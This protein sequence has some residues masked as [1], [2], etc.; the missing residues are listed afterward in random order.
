MI[1]RDFHSDTKSI[2]NLVHKEIQS[3][4][5]LDYSYLSTEYEYS[6]SVYNDIN[7]S[8]RSLKIKLLNSELSREAYE[9]EKKLVEKRI[10]RTSDKNKFTFKTYTS[11][12]H[13]YN[14]INYEMTYGF[15]I[16]KIINS[17]IHKTEFIDTR[18]YEHLSL[19]RQENLD[20]NI[21]NI[22][23]NINYYNNMY[24]YINTPSLNVSID[25]T[26][27]FGKDLYDMYMHVSSSGYKIGNAI[28]APNLDRKS[29]IVT[30]PNNQI[31]EGINVIIDEKDKRFLYSE[32][33]NFDYKYYEIP[34][35]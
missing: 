5:T 21:R 34:I 20:S 25:P 15:I 11:R 10:K 35:I 8:L 18:R 27:I 16:N 9:K 31:S 7:K 13:E 24:V 23:T 4:E 29:I 19:T 12:F 32:T 22:L 3:C 30:I 33:T 1:N 26:L 6:D 28:F 14:F 17:N 2:C